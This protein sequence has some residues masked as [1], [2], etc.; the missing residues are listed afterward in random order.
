MDAESREEIVIQLEIRKGRNSI[1]IFV[2]KEISKGTGIAKL[3]EKT[4][5]EKIHLG[6]TMIENCIIGEVLSKIKL[7]YVTLI[8]RK[9]LQT[10]T[11]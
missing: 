3:K 4:Q 11:H 7:M 8:L 5:R 10:A 2:Q 1:T 9:R 6:I